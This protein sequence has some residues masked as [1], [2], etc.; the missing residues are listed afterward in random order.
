MD[1]TD[2][3]ALENEEWETYKSYYLNE[4]RICNSACINDS[5]FKKNNHGNRLN[6]NDND[7]IK[8]DTKKG[9]NQMPM[10]KNDFMSASKIHYNSS[11]DFIN[12]IKEKEG[13]CEN[14]KERR[15]VSETENNCVVI[16]EYGRSIDGEINN[17]NN[18]KNKIEKTYEKD[19]DQDCNKKKESRGRD[20]DRH[21][22]K[23]RTIPTSENLEIHHR[24]PSQKANGTIKT[25]K[26]MP[27]SQGGVDQ[28]YDDVVTSPYLS[29][30]V[31][32][33]L[34]ILVDNHPG[35][36]SSSNSHNGRNDQHKENKDDE[37]P[38]G[39]SNCHITRGSLENDGKKASFLSSSSSAA[40]FREDDENNIY[41]RNNYDH[42]HK[43]NYNN[44]SNNH[45][46]HD[47]DTTDSLPM[48]DEEAYSLFDNGIS[49]MSRKQ[50][51]AT[52]PFDTADLEL[53]HPTKNTIPLSSSLIPSVPET[54]STLTTTDHCP[55]RL[56]KI[57]KDK[58][59]SSSNNKVAVVDD[60]LTD[61]F[62]KW[63]SSFSPSDHS[64]S[65][66]MKNH[67]NSK[68]QKISS[69][70]ND[71]Y[72]DDSLKTTKSSPS[73]AFTSTT[74]TTNV[75]CHTSYP[76]DFKSRKTSKNIGVD[77]SDEI[78]D[79][80]SKHGN[81]NDSRESK[82]MDNNQVSKMGNKQQRAVSA[83]IIDN[84]DDDFVLPKIPQTRVKP[85]LTSPNMHSRTLS[86]SLSSANSSKRLPFT[87]ISSHQKL[88]LPNNSQQ[89]HKLNSIGKIKKP[90]KGGFSSLDSKV[91]LTA[92]S[93][94]PECLIGG[95][96]KVK[97]PPI[98]K[99]RRLGMRRKANI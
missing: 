29:S 67:D 83:F 65:R 99:K 41:H 66:S 68:S 51:S 24:I 34:E 70:E 50:R 81:Y 26:E 39:S 76:N 19:N 28:S 90:Q 33:T 1:I 30:S 98:K 47:V 92:A 14:Q 2:L 96:E 20:G 36:N 25:A 13:L 53:D 10:V 93:L 11:R 56:N 5:T 64:N 37:G 80:C 38:N 89:Q 95:A 75:S 91:N 48:L 60:D 40:T 31:S 59:K 79:D 23:K 18:N 46:R 45:A 88:V 54:S 55:S 97:G 57:E 73:S 74:A 8:D 94:H 43:H 6:N 84:D 35:K 4:S 7:I 32:L 22:E 87:D 16:K 78:D 3:E 12:K 71:Y 52:N 72:T 21:L 61:D 42:K 86:S 49:N 62:V 27:K 77:K 85:K 44:S 82:K 15:V 58:N 9:E 17:N 69:Y 63:P